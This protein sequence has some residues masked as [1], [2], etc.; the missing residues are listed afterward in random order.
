MHVMSQHSHH[1][2]VDKTLSLA[3]ERSEQCEFLRGLVKKYK[4]ER[5]DL[6]PPDT[7]RPHDAFDQ[8]ISLQPRVRLTNGLL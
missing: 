4:C 7:T 8:L 2:T 3:S 5:P 1:M 6:T